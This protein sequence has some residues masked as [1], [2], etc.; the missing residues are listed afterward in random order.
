MGAQ[1]A[2][3]RDMVEQTPLR[4]L[5]R[6]IRE[7]DQAGVAEFVM[8]YE[9]YIRSAVR[10][11]MR[12]ARLR[13]VFDSADVCQSVLASFFARAALGQFEL[14]SSE[15]L[16]KLLN[17][18]ARNKVA[19][20]ARKPHVVRRDERPVDDEALDSGAFEPS[21][22]VIG[23]DLLE[24][25]HARLSDDERWLSDQR[26]GGRR[27]DEIATEVGAQPDA[28]R[29]KLQRALNRVARQLGLGGSS[30]E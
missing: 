16:I 22:H 3:V 25:F 1:F 23:R 6:R 13:R 20:Q 14:D 12:D 30:D 4:L 17:V 10:M 18:M 11:R 27:W 9:P 8:I 29:K 2:W 21:R 15:E 7:G 24:A 26:I 19:S 28:L 5:V